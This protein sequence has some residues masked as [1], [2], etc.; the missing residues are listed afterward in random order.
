[1]IG[2]K[3]VRVVQKVYEIPFYYLLFSLKS[4]RPGHHPRVKRT[5]MGLVV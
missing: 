5:A 1:M 3:S 4:E 2:A